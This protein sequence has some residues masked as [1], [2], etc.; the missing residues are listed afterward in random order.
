MPFA[1][2][3][4][5]SRAGTGHGPGEGR[6]GSADPPAAAERG[7]G[8]PAGRGCSGGETSAVSP[9]V[10]VVEGLQVL[11]EPRLSPR[12]V[13]PRGARVRALPGAGSVPA[14]AA[15]RVPPADC[16]YYFFFF[17]K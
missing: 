9:A 17:F 3:K 12:P 11:A 10:F 2:G 13:P 7:G 16:C 1:P 5:E 8:P 15:L 6:G 14:V 4:G